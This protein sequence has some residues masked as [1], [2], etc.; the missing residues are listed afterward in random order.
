VTTIR[1]RFPSQRDQERDR[2]QTTRAEK[3]NALATET[4]T[5]VKEDVIRD[6]VVEALVLRQEKAATIELDLG[7]DRE[8]ETV[9]VP[10][11]DRD[12]EA[13]AVEAEQVVDDEVSIVNTRVIVEVAHVLVPD[14]LVAIKTTLHVVVVVEHVLRHHPSLNMFLADRIEVRV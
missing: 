5:V 14:H 13:E 6:H 9:I 12:R 1:K 7:Q 2:D 3:T 8:N 10:G 4:E 11:Q